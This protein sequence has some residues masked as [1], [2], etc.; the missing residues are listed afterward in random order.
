MK[1][2]LNEDLK[3]AMKSKDTLRLNTIR[4]VKKYVQELETSVG[5]SGDATDAEIMK[6]INKL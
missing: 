3:S 6:I 4:L 1:S 5:H 2:R